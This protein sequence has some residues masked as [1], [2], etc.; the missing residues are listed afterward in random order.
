[1]SIH[2]LAVICAALVGVGFAQEF[3]AAISGSVHDPSGASIVAAKVIVTNLEK[4][5]SSEAATNEAGFYSVPFLLPGRY[6]VTVEASGFKKFIR[7]DIVLG[8][9]DK[10]ALN[11]SLEVGLLAESVTVT[12]QVSMLQTETA[13][14][15]GAVEQR[16]VEDLPNNGRNMFQVVFAMPGVYKP[17]TSQG[18]SFDIGSGIGNANPSINGASQG[19]NGRGWNTEV[20]IDGLADNRA[21]RD[22]VAVPALETVQELQVLTNMYDSSYGHTGGG[23]VSVITKSGTNALHGAVF[24]REYDAKWRAKTWAENFAGRTKNPSRLHNYG[25]QANGPVLIPKLFNGRDRL[26]FM[27][28][29]DKS[30]R[31]AQ[32]TQFSN[33]PSAAMKAGN[34]SA[35]RGAGGQPIVLYDPLTTRLDAGRYLRT[36]FAGNLI[37]AGRVDPVGAKIV[38]F[39]PDPNQPGGGVSGLERNLLNTGIQNDMTAQ[40]AGRLDLRLNQ[41]HT[42]FGRFTV[43]DQHRN[44]ANRFG[45]ASPA[46]PERTQRG[47]GGRHF[48]LDWTAALNPTTTWNLRTGFARFEETAGSDLSKQFDP[49]QLGWPAALVNQFTARNYPLF[50]FGF[51]QGHGTDQVEHLAAFDTYTL[52]ANLGKVIRS[53]VTKFGAEVR[54]YRGNRLDRGVASGNLA[55]GRGFTQADPLRADAFSGDEIA[56]LLLGYPNGSFDIPVAPAY[57]YHYY[58][59]FFQDDWKVTRKL[60]LNLGL[61]WDYESPPVERHDRMLRGFAFD[62]ASPIAAQVKSSP[63]AAN[64]PACADLRGGPLFAGV[65]GQPRTGFNPDRNN[66]QPRLGLAYSLTPKTVIRAGYGLY[67]MAI[68][69]TDGGSTLGFS[70]NTPI[71]SSTDGGLTPSV[72]LS[73]PAP[74]G[75]VRPVGASLGLSTNLGLGLGVNYLSRTLARSHQVSFGFQRQLPLAMTLDASYVGNYSTNLPV[76]FGLNF[77]PASQLGQTSSFYTTQVANPFQGLLP[78]NSGLNGATIPRQTLLTAYPQ[79]AGLSLINAPIGR[80]RYDSMQLTVRRRFSAGLT[81]QVNYMISKTLEQLQF[82][83]AQDVNL[84]DYSQSRLDKR[85]TPFDVPQRLSVIGVYDLPFGKG[86]RYAARMPWVAN[87]FLGGWTLGWNVTHQAGFPIDFPNAAPLE[88][89]SAKLPSDKRS[90]YRWYDTSLFPRV[91]GPAPFT[92]RNFSSRFP[93]VRF[94]SFDNWDLNLGKDVVIHERVKAQVRLTS[95]DTF[96]HPYFTQ[97]QSG[98]VTSSQFGQLTLSQSNPPRTFYLDF[99]LVF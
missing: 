93:D 48:S 37:P 29:W 35:L 67:Y 62:Q 71:I 32:F 31:D 66:L 27:L 96:N 79:Y 20:L 69:D 94:M 58:V 18:N 54:D 87:L 63:A 72:R 44:G 50:N 56:T 5:T 90:L 52:Q 57:S 38:S 1:M 19:T 9:N 60:A 77:L 43:T 95:V 39:Y 16:V 59:L 74:N 78:N 8:V 92:L 80:N 97:L 46:E 53:H 25:F 26:F 99:R 33:V 17:S 14:R 89:R 51:Y 86:R 49:I 15:G 81:F 23:V 82:L 64:C 10:L 36:P 34:F 12:G 83:N 7:Q 30:P 55:F 21:S 45:P 2:R 61:R 75:L 88:A 91:A 84:G 47:D 22:I 68:A 24:D 13:S 4:N 11:V 3:R 76:S 41:K 42:L 6:A 70:Q 98:N 65:G 85:V 73:N 40:W 28:S